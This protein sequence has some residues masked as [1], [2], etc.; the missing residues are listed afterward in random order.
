M[1]LAV[2]VEASPTLIPIPKLVQCR[3]GIEKRI[4]REQNWLDQS[5]DPDYIRKRRDNIRRLRIIKK[6]LRALEKQL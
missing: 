1:R 4:R 6:E 5:D 2:K 3:K